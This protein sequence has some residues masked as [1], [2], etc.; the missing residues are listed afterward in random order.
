MLGGGNCAHSL[1]CY[2][3][4]IGFSVRLWVRNLD[5][6]FSCVRYNHHIKA[7]GKLEGDF[8]FYWVGSDLA[9]AVKGCNM[10]FV[11][12]V[13]TAYSDVAKRL[14]PFIEPGQI[15]VTFSS[16]LAGSVEFEEVLRK[17]NPEV[18]EQVTV[19]E[20]DALFASRLQQNES[21]WVRG[22]K[23]WNLVCTPQ[24]K[25]LDKVLP[26]MQDMFPGLLP[27]DNIVQR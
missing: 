8:H 21:L 19:C 5:H 16:K 9:E 6:L 2:L 1:S 23:K 27:A 22:I 12:T 24:R 17:Y 7:Y 11:G 26:L 3:S 13:T 20:T 18:A 25:N 10:I 4:S 14:A 15:I